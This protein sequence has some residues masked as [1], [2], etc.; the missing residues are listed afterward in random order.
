MMIG[1]CRRFAPFRPAVLLAL[2]IGW[3]TICDH[4]ACAADPTL[5]IDG[6]VAHPLT[7]TVADLAALPQSD[8]RVAYLTGHGPEDATYSGVSLWSLIEKAGL[9][10]AFKDRRSH[11]AHYLLLSASDGY[12]VVLGLGEID[13][14]LEGKPALIALKRDGQPIDPKDIFRLAL[15]GDKHGARNMHDITRIELK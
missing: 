8:I 4:V 9:G 7:L 5:T 6:A 15:A 3:A 13:P 12:Q 11:S 10:D 1:E 14:E 2:T